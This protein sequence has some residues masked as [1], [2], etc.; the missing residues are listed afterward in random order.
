VSEVIVLLRCGGNEEG[1]R[2]K[3]KGGHSSGALRPQSSY[4]IYIWGYERAL[5]LA[6]KEVDKDKKKKGGRG[7]GR[8]E[9][10]RGGSYGVL[11]SYLLSLESIMF[12][13]M[14]G[15]E[16]FGN[17][18]GEVGEEK[19]KGKEGKGEDQQA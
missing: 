5:K 9:K 19:K 3:R 4:L 8:R 14:L 7:G 11:H 17:R 12:W 2:G 18:E 16:S 10:K 1:E 6:W 15:L 13:L